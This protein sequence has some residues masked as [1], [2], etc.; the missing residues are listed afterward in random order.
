MGKERSVLSP[1]LVGR[2]A[3]LELADA[4]L[5]EAAAGRGG[6][7][8]IA[9]EAGIGKSRLI[10]AIGRRARTAGFAVVKGDLAPVD[11][12]VPAAIVLE[13]AR[14]MRDHPAMAAAG[15]AIIARWRDAMLP[16]QARYSR[17]LVLDVVDHIR[18]VI[19]G[20]TLCIFEDLQW[21]DDL[22]LELIGELARLA[23]R[24]PLLVIGVYRRDGTSADA[25]LR[26]WRSRLVTQRL[27]EE[28]RLERLSLEETAT[29]TTLLLG[30]GLPA[31]R[32][33][34]AAVHRRSDGVPLHIEELVAAA[35]SLGAIDVGTIH[36]L[37]VPDSIEDAVLARISRL[38]PAAQQAA[39]AAAVLGRCFVPEILAVVMDV[40]AGELDA[41]LH[42]LVDHAILYPHGAPDAGF[43]DFRHQLLREALYQ[44]TSEGVRRGYHARAAAFGAGLE[45]TTDVH[46]SLH[47]AR[48]GMR[49]E[50]YRAA[51][52]GAAAAARV[53]AHREAFELYARAVDHMADDLPALERAEL[54]DRFSEEAAAIER[55]DVSLRALWDARS[56][57]AEAGRPDQAAAMLG[58]ILSMWRRDGRPL[59][60]RRS[61]LAEARA[62]I[63]A[64]PE[65]PDR[66]QAL[67]QWMFHELVLTVDANDV[68]LAADQQRALLRAIE[69]T[70][71]P[72]LELV[73]RLRGTM[74]TVIGGQVRDGLDQMVSLAQEA[75]ASGREEAGVT[76]FRDAA[77]FAARA[78]EYATARRALDEGL[79]YA[80][81]IQQSHCAHMMAAVQAIADWAEG[82]WDAAVAGGR[83]AVADPGCQRAPTVARWSLGYVALG[84]GDLETATAELHAA[85]DFGERSELIDFRLPPRWGLA[86]AAL[87][88]GD[89]ATAIAEVER[90]RELA[91]DAS[92]RA[93]FAPFVVTGVRAY[94]QAGRPEDAARWLASA[95]AHLAATPAFGRPALDHAAGLV[96]L[97]AGT[98]AIARRSLEAAVEGWDAVGRVWEA[99]WARLDLASAFLRTSRFAAAVALA[100]QVLDTADGLASPALRA[101]AE[102]VVR[103][104]RSRVVD[105]EPWHPLTTR[106]FEVARLVGEG[107]TNAEIGDAL[108][109]APK[110]ASSHVEHILAKLGA[111]RRAE[112]ATWASQVGRVSAP[113]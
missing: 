81:S 113:R 83:Q 69:G 4:R 35:R 32:D 109:I 66:D 23:D 1:I 21:A 99:S 45:G 16:G 28:V 82:A 72:D 86:E 85:L 91:E 110:T 49:A 89:A 92:E 101:R 20:P 17:T 97:A 112:I 63:L 10:G 78:M 30:T 77:L 105:A 103:H 51:S 38:S 104:G 76:A 94:Q 84:R 3:H 37:D 111:S 52:S 60:E 26:A 107:L 80:D 34:V 25:P 41:P 62:E 31:P 100:G 108:G 7:V 87:L 57:Y 67:H 8:L 56:A 79:V 46:A 42:E 19:A 50:A 29:V 33:V 43:H 44:S 9:G 5:T 70:A 90:A 48:A 61:L 71:D 18:Q 93:L 40:P 24:H 75:R 13:F 14:T 106:E 27:A 68:D 58:G 64:L 12:G 88:A 74:A 6:T 55:N 73:A 15:E 65:G 47:F 54:L 95:A 53:S 96:A 36:A 11:E 2:D 22:S 102:D 98:T 39:R 59:S